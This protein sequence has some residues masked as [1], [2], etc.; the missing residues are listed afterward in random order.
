MKYLFINEQIEWNNTEVGNDAYYYV[1]AE[2]YVTLTE[3]LGK[4]F[5]YGH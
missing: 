5:K 1:K 2:K 3:F 4:K